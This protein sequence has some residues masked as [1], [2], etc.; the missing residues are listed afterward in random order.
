MDDWICCTDRE[1]I[2]YSGLYGDPKSHCYNEKT[3][4]QICKE[5]LKRGKLEY[6]I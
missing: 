5:M 1:L 3:H 6:K 2:F 4:E